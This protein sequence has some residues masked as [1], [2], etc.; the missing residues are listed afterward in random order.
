MSAQYPLKPLAEIGELIDSLHKTPK[1]CDSGFPMVRVTDIRRGYLDLSST[2]RVDEST[3]AEF[4]KKYKPQEGD[5]LFTRVGSYGNSCYVRRAAEFC[6]GQNTVCISPSQTR[7]VPYYL[8]CCLN[9]DFVRGQIQSFIGGASQP[10][11]SLANINKICI[12]CPDLPTQRRIASILSAYD[13]LIENNTRRIKIL[14]EMAQMLYQEWFVHFRF[15]RHENVR[16][17]DSELGPIPEGWR[18]QSLFDVAQVTY[19][20]PFKSK[21]F[22]DGGDGR[23]VIRIR[24]IKANFSNTRTTEYADPKYVVEDGDLLVGMDGDFHMGK[25]SGSDAYL[26]QRV[27]RFRPK[28]DISPYFL[29]LSLQTPIQHFGSTIVGTTV[30]HLSDRDLRSIQLAVPADDVRA[31]LSLLFDPLFKLEITLRRKN[32]NLRTTRD[33]LLPKL[34]FGDI[35]VEAADDVAGELMEEVA[36]PA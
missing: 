36:Q 8:Y 34:I 4:V 19:G 22:V 35:P 27:V 23:P 18:A 26:N 21:L 10:T 5:T 2:L 15:P 1:Y 31:K 6:L 11:I 13:D 3:Y 14:E 33:L 30:A 17:V 29:F 25:W 20:F 9:S 24:D 16:M 7:I 32:S 12:P 28:I